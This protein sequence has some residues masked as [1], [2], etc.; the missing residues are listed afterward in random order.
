[1][2]T[3]DHLR[4]IIG[5]RLLG[6]KSSG[7]TSQAL[8]ENLG[9]LVNKNGHALIPLHC[10]NDFLRR[11]VEIV[12]RNNVQ[13]ALVDDFFAKLNIGAFKPDHQRNFEPHFLDR[14][15]DT[16]R[17]HIALHDATKDIDQNAFNGWVSSDDLKCGSYCY[18]ASATANSEEV[19][20]FC[21]IELDDIHGSHGQARTID[22][23]ANIAVQ[24]DVSEIVLGSFDFLLVFFG[25]VAQFEN[26]RMAVKR[27]AVERYFRIQNAQTTIF[28]DD[29]RVDF[30]KAHILFGKRFVEDRKQLQT[31]FT[32]FAFKRQRISQLGSIFIGHA[33]GWINRNSDDLFWRFFSNRFN[34]HTAFGR[35]DKSRTTN[36]AIDQQREIKLA[37]NICA[38]FDVNPIDLLASRTGLLGYQRITQHFFGVGDNFFNRLCQTNTA[39]GIFR[40]FF[41]LALATSA[42]MDLA[43]DDIKRS[44]KRLCTVFR[45]FDRINNHTVGDRRAVGVKQALGLVFVNIHLVALCGCPGSTGTD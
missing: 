16:F 37:L 31:I 13:T 4:A 30:E 44:G 22:H 42:S 41:E 17:D 23:A 27:I 43:F 38:I 32:R 1:M 12:G 24:C 6:M 25:K 36:R 3:T 39:L 26:I 40:Q 2:N 33:L 19:S 9:V 14:C 11:V 10:G 5:Q 35:N 15:N 21:T 28:H 45:L 29:Q 34:V 18:L 20:R 7:L 8:Y